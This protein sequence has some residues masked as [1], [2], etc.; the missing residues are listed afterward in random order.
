MGATVSF[1]PPRSINGKPVAP[2]DSWFIVT[3]GDRPQFHAF[4]YE[5]LKPDGPIPFTLQ[6]SLDLSWM[7]GC[8]DR[9]TAGAVAKRMGLTAWRYIVVKG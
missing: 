3:R 8:A 9:F 5:D 6:S 4:R 7:V 2:K 1:S